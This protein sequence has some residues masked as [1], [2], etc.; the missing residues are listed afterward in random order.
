MKFLTP[1]LI[2]LSLG[3]VA[4]AASS[5]SAPSPASFA[6]LLKLT[7]VQARLDAVAWRLD[8]ELS[9]IFDQMLAKD[10]TEEAAAFSAG[11]RVK[12]QANF[13]KEFT[14][15]TVT[16]ACRKENRE[17]WT[18]EEVDALLVLAK[19]PAGLSALKKLAGLDNAI[20]AS[21]LGRIAQFTKEPAQSLPAA[22]KEF[23]EINAKALAAQKGEKVKA[24][25]TNPAPATIT[26]PAPESA[27]SK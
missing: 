24:A 2:T 16:D 19:Q 18:Q 13:Q 4:H 17:G 1:F 10:G 12:V 26:P 11:F 6:E 23:Q 25:E 5:Q 9:G 20:E 8:G 21:T 22:I 27:K 15:Q 7:D 14:V 3:V